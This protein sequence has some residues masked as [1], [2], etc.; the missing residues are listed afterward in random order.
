[1]ILIGIY[2]SAIP[3]ASDSKLR[4]SIKKYATSQSRFLNNIGVAQ[5]EEEIEQRVKY[6][7][8]EIRNKKLEEIVL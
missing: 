4:Q 1:M 5:K 2:S 6:M 7:A 3:V 8:K